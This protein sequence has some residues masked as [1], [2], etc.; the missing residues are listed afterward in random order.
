MSSEVEVVRL[1]LWLVLALEVSTG[2][3]RSNL[4]LRRCSPSSLISLAPAPR[5]LWRRPVEP[6]RRFV[7]VEAAGVALKLS[8]LSAGDGAA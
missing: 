7:D 2:R 1:W 6:N 3:S 5:L 4:V 8:C